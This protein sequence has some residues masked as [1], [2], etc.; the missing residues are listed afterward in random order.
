MWNTLTSPELQTTNYVEKNFSGEESN[1]AC[2]MVQGIDSLEVNSNT[3][4]DYNASSSCDNNMDADALN[5]ELS[6]VYENL[7]SKYK[8]LKKKSYKLN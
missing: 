5:E 2:I 3:Q 6:I 1:Q 7:L 8:V 4:L